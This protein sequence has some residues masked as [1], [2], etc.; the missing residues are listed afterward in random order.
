MQLALNRARYAQT[1]HISHRF[2]N[3]WLKFDRF[4][5]IL[6]ILYKFLSEAKDTVYILVYAYKSVQQNI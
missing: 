3:S 4:S 5:N 1:T 6:V 2:N